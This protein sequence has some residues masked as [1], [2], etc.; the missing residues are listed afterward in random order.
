MEKK[1]YKKP[2]MSMVVLHHSTRLLVGSSSGSKSV[3]AKRNAYGDATIYNWGDGA[4]NAR[5]EDLD[6]ITE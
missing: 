4:S 5:G 6:E 3:S 1:E 2:M